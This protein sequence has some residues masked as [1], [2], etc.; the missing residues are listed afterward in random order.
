MDKKSMQISNIPFVFFKYFA[1]LT[2][3]M[4]AVAF[5]Q[6][7]SFNTSENLWQ[8][9]VFTLLKIFPFLIISAIAFL[10]ILRSRNRTKRKHNSPAITK[11]RIKLCSS[12]GK[13]ALYLDICDLLFIKN[14]DAYSCIYY[15]KNDR[16]EKRLLRGNLSSFEK[17][18]QFPL[19]RVHRSFVVNLINVFKIKGK[20]QEYKLEMEQLNM[21]IPVSKKYTDTLLKACDKIKSIVL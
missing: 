14:E 2:V 16:I 13:E 7:D 5:Y 1:V 21:E 8:R 6:S 19:I 9:H 17:Q 4:M 11:R 12:D 18:L 10:L 20:T 15:L 3:L